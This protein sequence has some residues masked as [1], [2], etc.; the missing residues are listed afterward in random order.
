MF[1]EKKSVI[2]KNY[3]KVFCRKERTSALEEQ[4]GTRFSHSN[5]DPSHARMNVLSYCGDDSALGEEYFHLGK[6]KFPYKRSNLPMTVRGTL[7]CRERNTSTRGEGYSQCG[8]ETLPH[9]GWSQVFWQ[10]GCFPFN[11]YSSASL[12][13]FL[14]W[15]PTTTLNSFFLSFYLGHTFPFSHLCLSL[16]IFHF[17][18]I[19]FIFLYPLF[20][21]YACSLSFHLYFI[22]RSWTPLNSLPPELMLLYPNGPAK[23]LN[24][25]AV[26]DSWVI[27]YW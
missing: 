27:G 4:S 3:G 26:W 19:P 11:A 22:S 23:P 7:S 25:R 14:S 12:S 15:H 24:S 18:R 9:T 1:E 6:Q 20:F 10:G 16:Y 5:K 21:F 17:S 13:L 2:Q 8:G